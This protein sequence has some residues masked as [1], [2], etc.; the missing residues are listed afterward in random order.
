MFARDAVK[1]AFAPASDVEIGAVDR[2]YPALHRHPFPEPVGQLDRHPARA[3]GL[4][5]HQLAPAIEPG[6]G[7]VAAVFGLQI[8][9]DRG[10]DEPVERLPQQFVGAPGGGPSDRA[11]Q[12]VGHQVQ[13]ARH[14]VDP[15]PGHVGENAGAVDQDVRVPDRRHAVIRI[16]ADVDVDRAVGTGVIDRLDPPGLSQGWRTAAPSCRAGRAWAVR[17]YRAGTG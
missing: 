3:F 15:A 14:V 2:Q 13:F 9:L 16:G 5:V 10:R 17:R 7:R 8:G 1:P 4:F 6:E 12:V 11:Q